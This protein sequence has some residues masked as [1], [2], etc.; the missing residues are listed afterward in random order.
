MAED[1]FVF[2]PSF[3]TVL[4]SIPDKET[5]DRFLWAIVEYGLTGETPELEYPL[6]LAMIQIAQSIDSAKRRHRASVENGKKGGAPKGNQNN[7]K[8]REAQA[9]KKAEGEGFNLI[10][11]DSTQNNPIQP[12]TTQ[13]NPT[14][15]QGQPKF[16]PNNNINNNININNDSRRC[17]PG[18]PAAPR[19]QGRTLALP[20][21]PPDFVRWDGEVYRAASGNTYRDYINKEGMLATWQLTAACQ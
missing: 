19:R 21:I 10:Q 12:E 14:S 8:W 17:A 13:F 4:N 7:R 18:T 11:P 3:L 9:R 2:Y 15:T 20:E 16:N 1:G 5:R 6:N